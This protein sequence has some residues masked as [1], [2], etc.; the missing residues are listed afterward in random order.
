MGTATTPAPTTTTT[1]PEP[2]TTT[3]EPTTT[4]PSPTTTTPEPTTTTSEPTTTTPA[5]TTTKDPTKD[6]TNDPI[7]DPTSQPTTSPTIKPCDSIIKYKKKYKNVPKFRAGK[8]GQQYLDST[9]A[10]FFE[11]NSEC[12]SNDDAEILDYVYDFKYRT[13]KEKLIVKL[14]VCCAA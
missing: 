11:D 5:P 1:T 14:F 13:K 2:T 10:Y 6:P 9:I 3:S 4:T 12:G 8:Q 7:N